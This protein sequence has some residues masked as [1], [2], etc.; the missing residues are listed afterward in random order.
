MKNWKVHS[1]QSNNATGNQRTHKKKKSRLYWGL[2]FLSV[3]IGIIAFTELPKLIGSLLF[4]VPVVR[5]AY[6]HKHMVTM[7]KYSNH[8]CSV[9]KSIYNRIYD[10]IS[11]IEIPYLDTLKEKLRNCKCCGFCTA[12]KERVACGIRCINSLITR[13]CKKITSLYSA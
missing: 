13:L 6:K 2:L 12:I 5:K 9:I 3:I 1:K 7:R 10:M 11:S 8:G 4:T